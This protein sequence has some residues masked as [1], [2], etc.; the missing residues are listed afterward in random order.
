MISSPC[1]KV[2]TIDPSAGLCAG[3]G[4][5]LAEIA[6]WTSLS[7][8]ERERIMAELP[9]RLATFRLPGPTSV[10]SP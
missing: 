6:R 8:T 3:C 9:Q 1:I 5:S 4:R 7:N 2:C 10:P